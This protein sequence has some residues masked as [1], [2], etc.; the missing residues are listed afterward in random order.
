VECTARLASTS[1]MIPRRCAGVLAT[2]MIVVGPIPSSSAR[3]APACAAP[4]LDFRYSPTQL[5]IRTTV[6]PCESSRPFFQRVEVIKNDGRSPFGFW[7]IEQSSCLAGSACRSAIRLQHQTWEVATYSI[8]LTETV[9]GF[10]R[11][12]RLGRFVCG[13]AVIQTSCQAF[14]R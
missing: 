10:E 11:K 5:E 1:V 7:Y 3:D 2:L 14:D 4:T 9:D 12:W 6:Q 13:S 8:K